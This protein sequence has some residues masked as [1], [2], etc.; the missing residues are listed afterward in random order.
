MSTPAN[1][2]I[3]PVIQALINR[4]RVQIDEISTLNCSRAEATAL[5]PALSGNAL[6]A[7]IERTL[8]H[9][10]YQTDEGSPEAKVAAWMPEVCRR[11]QGEPSQAPNTSNQSLALDLNTLLPGFPA[12][13]DPQVA[14]SY[15]D[16]LYFLASDAAGRLAAGV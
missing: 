9:L 6:A 16:A 4:G 12:P 10:N 3:R 2:P 5:I 11:L 14:N 8:A 7:R 13:A 15:Q 1:P